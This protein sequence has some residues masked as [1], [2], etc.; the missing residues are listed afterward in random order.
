MI[1]LRS[2][3]KINISLDLTG[4]RNDGYHLLRTVM[5]TISLSDIIRMEKLESAQIKISCNVPYI[6]TDERNIVHK[7]ATA[8]FDY[9]G[10]DAGVYVRLKKYIPS[11]AGLGG[12]SS[13]GAAVLEGLCR[14]Y[15]V[16]MTKDQRVRLT[17]KIGADI[18]FFVYGGTALCEGIGEK[19][20]PL[21]SLPQC[22]IVIAKPKASLSTASVFSS[23]Q[24]PQVFEI[25]STDTVL[26]KLEKGDIC[27]IFRYSQNA[28]EDAAI[29]KCPVIA[30]IKKT[31]YSQGA[32]FSMMS[33]SGSAVYGVF[34]DRKTARAAYEYVHNLCKCTYIAKPCSCSFEEN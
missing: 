6:P 30:N 28:L 10:I 3:A 21:S 31:M 7:I 18:P 19:V 9:T 13:N 12:G 4:R 27:E 23:L 24:I 15:D 25:S 5:Q 20:T 11:G 17:E 2:P 32:V 33:G 1:V 29:A 14:L 34:T 22:W 26:E 16:T 8:F